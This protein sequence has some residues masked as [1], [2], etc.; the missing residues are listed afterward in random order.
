VTVAGGLR[1]ACKRHALPHRSRAAAIPAVAVLLL[2]ALSGPVSAD[3]PA[4]LTITRWVDGDGAAGPEGCGGGDDAFRTIQRAVKASDRND[5]VVVC[6]GRY[7]ERV[8]IGP[9]RKGLT[10]VGSPDF[11]SIVV[12]PAADDGIPVVS[13]L[14]APGVTLKQLTFIVG[15]GDGCAGDGPARPA[16]AAI[17][18]D[19]SARTTIRGNVIKPVGGDTIS[20]DCGFR[21]GIDVGGSQDVVLSANIIRDF[22][23]FGIKLWASSGRIVG[24]TI[25]YFHRT[26]SGGVD[27]RTAGIFGEFVSDIDI[28]DNT[29]RSAPSASEITPALGMGVRLDGDRLTIRDN[30]MLDVGTGVAVGGADIRSTTT[31]WSAPGR[32]TRRGPWASGST[33]EVAR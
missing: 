15:S 14:H 4:R 16:D 32:R 6:P 30:T 25:R 12:A 20:D 23:Q 17:R 8:L 2:S 7:Q 29:I 11:T 10:L 1:D 33:S 26:E 13:V 31:R 21:V 3:P 28:Q 27:T 5:R 24:N 22:Q 9:V 18:V 19:A